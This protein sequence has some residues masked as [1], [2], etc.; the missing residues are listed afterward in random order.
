MKGAISA[1]YQYPTIDEHAAFAQA[2]LLSLTRTE[3]KNKAGMLSKNFWLQS[4]FK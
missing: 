3:A 1:N 2:W 4:F